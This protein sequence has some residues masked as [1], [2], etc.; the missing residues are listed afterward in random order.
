[1]NPP[2]KPLTA[3]EKK[4]AEQFLTEA[5]LLRTGTPDPDTSIAAANWEKWFLSLLGQPSAA[6]PA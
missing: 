6:L 1:M 2:A 3:A 4:I 5:R